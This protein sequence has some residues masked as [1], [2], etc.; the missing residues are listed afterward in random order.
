MTVFFLEEISGQTYE[1]QASEAWSFVANDS[2]DLSDAQ[3]YNEQQLQQND[4]TGF[5]LS[6][7]LQQRPGIWGK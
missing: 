7:F 4:A 2:D 1:S 5:S 6:F 3:G